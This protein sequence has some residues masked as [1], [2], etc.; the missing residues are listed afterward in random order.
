M[1]GLDLARIVDVSEHINYS[2]ILHLYFPY[3]S[4][5][6]VQKAGRYCTTG[7]AAETECCAFESQTR[8][9][10]RLALPGVNSTETMSAEPLFENINIGQEL[11]FAVISIAVNSVRNSSILRVCRPLRST[12]PVSP[13]P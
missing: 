8:I 6:I 3:D 5:T 9:F 10:V 2:E 7:N 12:P 13:L 1:L 11:T 4:R